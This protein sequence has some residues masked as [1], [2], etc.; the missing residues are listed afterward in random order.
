MSVRT[1]EIL[2]RE[3]EYR[4]VREA[5]G[6]CHVDLIMAEPSPRLPQVTCDPLV[7]GALLGSPMRGTA[8]DGASDGHALEAPL[9]S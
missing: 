9:V 7:S 1:E 2:Q 4:T 6:T 3:A 8:F 5:L